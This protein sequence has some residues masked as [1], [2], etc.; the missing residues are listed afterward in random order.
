MSLTYVCKAIFSKHGL[1]GLGQVIITLCDRRKLRE[2]GFIKGN[3]DWFGPFSRNLH[4]RFPI[5][6]CTHCETIVNIHQ[7]SKPCVKHLTP[8]SV[9]FCQRLAYFQSG[10]NSL[11]SLPSFKTLCT[12]SLW[13][14]ISD[15]YPLQI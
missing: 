9:H 3:R 14:Y 10:Q 12:S 4:F 5:R 6:I 15:Q 13:V 2:P 1:Y 7:K 11:K 8:K